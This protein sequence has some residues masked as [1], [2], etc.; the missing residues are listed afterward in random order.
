MSPTVLRVGASRRFVVRIDNVGETSTTEV[1]IT[2]YTPLGPY[3][4]PST[5]PALVP[6]S[7][8]LHAIDLVAATGMRELCAV[9][10]LLDPLR[11]HP[12]DSNAEDNRLCRTLHLSR[13]IQTTNDSKGDRP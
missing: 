12:A 7:R 5:V 2:A 11:T 9:A 4:R 13:P 8:R 3:G 1:L 6:G 10:E